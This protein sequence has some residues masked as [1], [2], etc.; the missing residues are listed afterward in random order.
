M[1]EGGSE[2]QAQHPA[3][4][5]QH[6]AKSMRYRLL[7]LLPFDG[8]S[9]MRAV[10]YLAERLLGQI[11]SFTLRPR[12][13]PSTTTRR[14]LC[15]TGGN[16]LAAHLNLSLKTTYLPFVVDGR[17]RGHNVAW[18]FWTS[19]TLG[20]KS[21][22]EIGSRA[23]AIALPSRGTRRKPIVLSALARNSRQARCCCTALFST[24]DCITFCDCTQKNSMCVR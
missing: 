20:P 23:Y 24:L 16:E 17:L 18:G 1:G 4:A 5:L 21:P 14:K 6:R 9:H 8:Q 7:R 11:P 3:P 2:V 22:R 19:Q 12:R 10:G 13:R 15:G